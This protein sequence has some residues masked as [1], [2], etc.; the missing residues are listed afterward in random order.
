MAGRARRTRKEHENGNSSPLA[1]FLEEMFPLFPC[2]LI[3]GSSPPF[4]SRFTQRNPLTDENGPSERGRLSRGTAA[5]AAFVEAFI[6]LIGGGRDYEPDIVVQT[7]K[8][9]LHFQLPCTVLS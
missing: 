8:N 4:A 1:G 6:H 7:K 5:T 2:D 3:N 9:F